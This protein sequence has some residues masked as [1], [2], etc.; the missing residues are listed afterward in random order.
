MKKIG[1]RQLIR[2]FTM[3][4]KVAGLKLSKGD[5]QILSSLFT[6]TIT[7]NLCSGNKVSVPGLGVFT[8]KIRP[9]RTARNPKTNDY[10]EVPQRGACKF[11]ATQSV[12]QDICMFMPAEEVK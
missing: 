11:K 1:S 8:P 6:D 5:A 2:Q 12:L 9:G 4:A 10:V 3:L 7:A